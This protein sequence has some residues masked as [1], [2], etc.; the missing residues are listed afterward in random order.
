MARDTGYMSYKLSGIPINNPYKYKNILIYA[1]KN[2]IL[3]SLR[4]K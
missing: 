1:N 3:K 2:V 4:D